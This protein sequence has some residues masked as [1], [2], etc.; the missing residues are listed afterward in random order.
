MHVK[1]CQNLINVRT[2]FFLT[3]VLY[4]VMSVTYPIFFLSSLNARDKIVIFTI[5]L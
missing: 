4:N 2:I 3:I 5:D 1:L